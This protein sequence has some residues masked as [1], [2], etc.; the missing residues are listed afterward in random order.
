MFKSHYNSSYM[1]W[2]QPEPLTSTSGPRTNGYN[3]VFR[4]SL[5]PF[6][7]HEPFLTFYLVPVHYAVRNPNTTASILT[8]PKTHLNL[9]PTN[10]IS[11]NT[12]SNHPSGYPPNAQSASNSKITYLG[13]H[14]SHEPGSIYNGSDLN[15]PPNLSFHPPNHKTSTSHT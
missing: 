2:L 4:H 10:S 14:H 8:H 9:Y 6:P 1:S 15:T 11:I 7:S 5:E 3:R 12:E 13:T